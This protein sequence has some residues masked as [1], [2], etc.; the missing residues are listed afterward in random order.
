MSD[1]ILNIIGV[2]GIAI[3]ALFIVYSYKTGD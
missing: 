3:I 2:I 1:L